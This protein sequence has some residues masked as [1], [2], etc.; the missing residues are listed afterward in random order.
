MNLEIS[1]MITPFYTSIIGVLIPLF[2]LI[3][4]DSPLHLTAYEISDLQYF[5]VIGISAYFQTLFLNLAFSYDD[6]SKISPVINFT[7]L[8][9]YLADIFVF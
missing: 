1:L 7:V 9:G 5:L 6:A 4:N 2:F 3:F 8:I